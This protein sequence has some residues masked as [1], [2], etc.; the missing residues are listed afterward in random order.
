MQE[1]IISLPVTPVT[2]W[3]MWPA[4][5]D[6]STSK[7]NAKLFICVGHA[8]GCTIAAQRRAKASEGHKLKTERHGNVPRPQCHSCTAQLPPEERFLI[9]LQSNTAEKV[10]CCVFHRGQARLNYRPHLKPVLASSRWI[11]FFLFLSPSTDEFIESD[12][13]VSDSW[14]K[15]TGTESQD[16]G[17]ERERE[18]VRL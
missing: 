2:H 3:L 7:R 10:G 5:Q 12:R 16:T 6:E 8:L 1:C 14:P 4:R 13:L 18:T 9:S 15:Q 17:Q 11:F